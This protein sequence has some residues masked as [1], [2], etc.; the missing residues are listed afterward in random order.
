M[1]KKLGNNMYKYLFWVPSPKPRSFKISLKNKYDRKM[2]LKNLCFYVTVLILVNK[3]S[4]D[5]E[6]RFVAAI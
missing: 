2:I 4:I 5:V 6:N 3:F 1:L